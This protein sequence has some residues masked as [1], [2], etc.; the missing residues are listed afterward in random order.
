[1]ST[2]DKGVAATTP[3]NRYNLMGVTYHA[4]PGSEIYR[5]YAE[6]A[7]CEG[8]REAARFFRDVRDEDRRRAEVRRAPAGP[9]G[10]P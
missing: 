8:N 7:E 1:M 3:N 10:R 2:E 4:L 6:D 9:P 5:K